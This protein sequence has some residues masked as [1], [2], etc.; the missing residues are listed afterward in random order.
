M[1]RVGTLIVSD[2]QAKHNSIRQRTKSF[3]ADLDEV[4]WWRPRDFRLRWLILL[5]ASCCMTLCSTPQGIWPPLKIY[6]KP[7]PESWTDPSP[8]GLMSIWLD[9]TFPDLGA[10][11][12][13]WEAASASA[14]LEA[15]ME[16]WPFT[17][18]TQ[19]NLP[20]SQGW[21]PS[22]IQCQIRLLLAR[23]RNY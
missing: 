12:Q 18:F 17:L 3:P 23:L 9:H 20:L 10:F 1:N 6:Q 2:C 8:S 15:G 14:P 13:K 19:W 22:K 16:Q 4:L 11:P 5:V 21:K 7:K